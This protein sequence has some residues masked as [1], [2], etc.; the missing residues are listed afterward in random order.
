MTFHSIHLRDFFS[1]KNAYVCRAK[2]KCLDISIHLK[3][4]HGFTLD[5]SY[6]HL[7]FEVA[8]HKAACHFWPNVV[9]KACQFHLCQARWRKIQALGLFAVYKKILRC[10]DFIFIFLV[11]VF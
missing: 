2:W 4:M 1:E 8:V 10:R 7:D 6:L 9:V 11:Y 3:V 5:I